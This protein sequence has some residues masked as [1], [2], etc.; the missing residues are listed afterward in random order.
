MKRYKV[1]FN[2]PQRFIGQKL[3]GEQSDSIFE[4]EDDDAARE[5][6]KTSFAGN[7]REIEKDGHKQRW[8]FEVVCLE[9]CPRRIDLPE[10][11]L[12]GKPLPAELV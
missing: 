7:H 5:Y 3:Y 8:Y 11:P 12:N 10:L 9:E 4:A 6:V 1:T 2:V